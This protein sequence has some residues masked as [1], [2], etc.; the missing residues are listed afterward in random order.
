MQL[1][2]LVPHLFLTA[3]Q[4]DNI[5]VDQQKACHQ[6]P[7]E[8]QQLIHRF[9]D[10]RTTTEM[11]AEIDQ[12]VATLE[13]LFQLVVQLAQPGDIAVDRPNRPYPPCQAKDAKLF[14]R[15]GHADILLQVV[16]LA[17]ANGHRLRRLP[18]QISDRGRG[19]RG[20]RRPEEPCSDSALSSG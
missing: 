15:I 6:R 20:G 5:V 3:A 19:E 12:T 7:A 11:I 9:A 13:A 2:Q 17:V 8:D 10:V 14:G 1:Q 18:A 16:G 4:K